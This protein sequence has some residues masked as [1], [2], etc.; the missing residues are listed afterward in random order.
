MVIKV[1][2]GPIEPIEDQLKWAI[3]G[4]AVEFSDANLAS[5]SDLTEITRI[6]KFKDCNSK[7]SKQ[8][9]DG[10]DGP[11]ARETGQ[12]RSELEVSILGLMALRG[13]T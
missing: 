3:E 12:H 9:R 6:Y 5:M 13:A 2:S 10:P 1:T 7:D 8:V 4:R 11:G